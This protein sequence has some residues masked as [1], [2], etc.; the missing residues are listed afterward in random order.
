MVGYSHYIRVDT[1]GNV[2]HAFSDAFEQ[3]K[4]GDILVTEGGSRHFNLDLWYNGVIPRWYVTGDEMIERTDA[5]L[6]IQWHQYQ[7]AHPPEQSELE[8]L[9]AENTELKLAL[10]ELAEAQEAD[11]TEVQ[12]ALAE[13]AGLIGGE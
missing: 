9:R 11:K 10:T 12:L 13:I 1:D 3:A 7:V 5:E 2:I 4:D 6:S 8:K